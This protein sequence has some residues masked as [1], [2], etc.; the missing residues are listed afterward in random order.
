MIGGPVPHLQ[1]DDCSYGSTS[2][3]S[4]FFVRV[5]EY[6][7]SKVKNPGQDYLLKP[8][9]FDWIKGPTRISEQ[10]NRS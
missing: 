5:P 8:R 1:P 3:G 2:P 9:G 6:L 4:A 10:L 7:K